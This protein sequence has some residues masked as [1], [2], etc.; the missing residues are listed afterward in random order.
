MHQLLEVNLKC[1]VLWQIINYLR[2]LKEKVINIASKDFLLQHLV[3]HE[4]LVSRKNEI[5]EFLEGLKSLGLLNIVHTKKETCQVL[6]TAG[7]FQPFTADALNK[8][9]C[10]V[11]MELYR[12]QNSIYIFESCFRMLWCLIWVVVKRFT[13][14]QHAA[15][16]IRD[17]HF[18]HSPHTL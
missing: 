14:S 16:H 12:G 1:E 11:D 7:E 13:Y 10:E 8:M 9:I 2:W 6:F 4:L 5:E 17:T 18:K 15:L 3:S